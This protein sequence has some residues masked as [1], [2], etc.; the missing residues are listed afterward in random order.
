[1][2]RRRCMYAYQYFVYL[3][4]RS[5]IEEIISQVQEK[6]AEL[7]SLIEDKQEED[8]HKNKEKQGKLESEIKAADDVRKA[9]MET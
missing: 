6:L 8:K 9:A 1:M 7:S 2:H 4:I 5:G 3:N